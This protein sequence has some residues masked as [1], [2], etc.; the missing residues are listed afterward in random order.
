MIRLIQ[1]GGWDF[2]IYIGSVN[3]TNPVN[4]WPTGG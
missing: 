1:G 3:V 4:A 2:T